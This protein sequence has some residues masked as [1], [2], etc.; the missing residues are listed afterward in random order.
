MRE[1]ERKVE[2][3]RRTCGRRRRKY[4][5]IYIY[6]CIY[7]HVCVYIYIVS[8]LKSQRDHLAYLEEKEEIDE[9]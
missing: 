3:E 7:I 5:N 9:G 4:Y 8:N 1:R 6:I 2:I